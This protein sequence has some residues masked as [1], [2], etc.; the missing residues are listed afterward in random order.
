M[1]DPLEGNPLVP[2]THQIRVNGPFCGKCQYL[3]KFE[4]LKTPPKCSLFDRVLQRDKST[5]HYLRCGSC[6]LAGGIFQS[7]E[8]END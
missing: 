3:L 5:V 7:K 4:G 6:I 2:K 1:I 8:K